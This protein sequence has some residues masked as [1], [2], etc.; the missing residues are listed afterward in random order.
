MSQNHTN[1]SVKDELTASQFVD[2]ITIAALMARHL[3]CGK[4]PNHVVVD[5]LSDWAVA[6][7]AFMDK[8]STFTDGE[9]DVIRR[10]SQTF[11]EACVGT[12]Q[13]G[14]PRNLS[15]VCFDL[16]VAMTRMEFRK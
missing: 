3:V 4:E 14:R 2:I 12:A 10:H 5:C 6:A 11:L 15:E 16:S 9:R 13:G 8:P 1:R 7:R